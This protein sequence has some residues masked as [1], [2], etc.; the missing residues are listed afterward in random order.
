MTPQKI[1]VRLALV[2]IEKMNPADRADVYDAVA[3]IMNSVHPDE[4][5][6]ARRIADTIR[7]AEAAQMKFSVLL[8]A[9]DEQNA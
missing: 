3:V 7:E 8:K 4:S 2:G 6:E 1:I 9:A 5:A